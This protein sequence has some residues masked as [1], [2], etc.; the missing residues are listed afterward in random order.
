MENY[1]HQDPLL[2]DRSV[3]AVCFM[4][5]ECFIFQVEHVLKF[6]FHS[7]LD[8]LEHRWHIEH[9]KKQGF[10]MLKSACR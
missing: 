8:R 7:N 9:F 1:S 5:V 3:V 10:Q 4:C 2:I 6:P